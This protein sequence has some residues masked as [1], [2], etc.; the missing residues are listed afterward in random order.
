MT[1]LRVLLNWD[2]KSD[3][4]SGRREIKRKIY[5]NRRER[6]AEKK[7]FFAYIFYVYVT[8]RLTDSPVL[9]ILLVNLF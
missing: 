5:K 6:T 2:F 8:D 7:F 9:V 1:T 3:A 4:H